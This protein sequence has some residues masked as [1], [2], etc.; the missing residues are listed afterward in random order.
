MMG[1]SRRFA[2]IAG[3]VMSAAVGVATGIG[4][5]AV[6]GASSGAVMLAFAMFIELGR[7]ERAR[8]L[9][10]PGRAHPAPDTAR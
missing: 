2:I 8:A 9:A 6:A 4:E 10:A 5:G 1:R 7:G 3:L